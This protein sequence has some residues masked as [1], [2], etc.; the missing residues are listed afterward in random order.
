MELEVDMSR[1][2]QERSIEGDE[3][4]DAGGSRGGNRS[5]GQRA[6]EDGWVRVRVRVF[7]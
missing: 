6:G 4:P 7:E 5:G 1:G 3:A 2:Q